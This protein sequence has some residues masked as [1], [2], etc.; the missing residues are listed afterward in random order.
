MVAE[1]MTRAYASWLTWWKGTLNSDDYMKFLATKVQNF[2]HHSNVT[3]TQIL[4]Q[5]LTVL[6]SVHAVIS[7]HVC[8]HHLV[9]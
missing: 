7:E 3:Y 4:D 8:P 9:V 1:R 2:T 5:K 6:W